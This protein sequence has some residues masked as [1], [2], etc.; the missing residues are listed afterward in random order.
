MREFFLLFDAI[1]GAANLSG[2][3][4]KRL[5]A[6]Y[7]QIK[8]DVL[9]VFIP[10]KQ[11]QLIVLKACACIKLTRISQINSKAVRYSFKNRYIVEIY[12]AC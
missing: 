9:F 2:D 3:I 12:Q 11:S 6:L 1:H 10:Y 4:R 7:P 5:A 8:V